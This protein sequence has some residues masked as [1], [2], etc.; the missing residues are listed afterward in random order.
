MGRRAQALSAALDDIERFPPS[1]AVLQTQH[2]IQAIRRASCPCCCNLAVPR[3]S[4]VRMLFGHKQPTSATSARLRAATCL[5][6]HAWQRLHCCSQVAGREMHTVG[7]A[8]AATE[9][10]AGAAAPLQ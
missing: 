5:V 6:H 7:M 1:E 2:Y 10:S 9:I 3:L 8:G 4:Q